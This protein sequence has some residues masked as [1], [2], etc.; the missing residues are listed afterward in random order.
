MVFRAANLFGNLQSLSS[1]YFCTKKSGGW[2][3]QPPD[4]ELEGT[5]IFFTF[6]VSTAAAVTGL[7]LD[8]EITSPHN[9]S[10]SSHREISTQDDHSQRLAEAGG[11][12]GDGREGGGGL[13]L[14]QETRWDSGTVGQW[15]HYTVD[16]LTRHAAHVHNDC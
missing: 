8:T 5:E 15:E 10:L 4:L 11:V 3:G 9:T 1:D 6:Y 7:T 16:T 2:P 14:L 13:S 12:T